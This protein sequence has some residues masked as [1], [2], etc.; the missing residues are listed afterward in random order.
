LS[1]HTCIRRRSHCEHPVV[2][3]CSFQPWQV[4]MFEGNSSRG[5]R[6]FVARDLSSAGLSPRARRAGAG[7][8]RA[9]RMISIVLDACKHVFVQELCQAYNSWVAFRRIL[10]NYC[11]FR[12]SRISILPRRRRRRV[13]PVACFGEQVKILHRQ[14][15]PDQGQYE[16]FL[17]SR[18]NL[19]VGNA[20][21]CMV[22]H[23]GLFG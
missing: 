16:L 7:A 23:P 10:E 5:Y 2:A 21:K 22:I 18:L 19:A 17:Q 1:S 14:S 6:S 3:F 4:N 20:R 13:F 12:R 9:V 15:L 8:R 11:R